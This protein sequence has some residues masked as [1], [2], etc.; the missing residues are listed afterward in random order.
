MLQTIDFT[1][2]TLL[3]KTCKNSSPGATRSRT[4]HRSTEFY[5]CPFI[6]PILRVRDP[7]SAGATMCCP[8][9]ISNKRSAR[10]FLFAAAGCCYRSRTSSRIFSEFLTFHSA[11]NGFGNGV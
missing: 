9:H 6:F 10:S 11:L 1:V 2:G 3:P 4:R 8:I 5:P 7:L